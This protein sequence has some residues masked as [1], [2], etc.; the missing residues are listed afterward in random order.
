MNS[1]ACGR[2][3]CLHCLPTTLL[4]VTAPQ[5]EFP[6]PQVCWQSYLWVGCSQVGVRW[7]GGGGATTQIQRA[8]YLTRSYPI[9]VGWFHNS[10]TPCH[11][12]PCVRGD[13][14]RVFL[15]S[16]L[17]GLGE[18]LTSWSRNCLFTLHYNRSCGSLCRERGHSGAPQTLLTRTRARSAI[19]PVLRS[20]F[21]NQPKAVL[22]RGLGLGVISTWETS[23]VEKTQPEGLL[24]TLE[25]KPELPWQTD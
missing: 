13:L 9:A 25:R 12:L 16:Y 23:T 1:N 17:C 5:T 14:E 10:V 4:P 2:C 3:Y 19:R 18:S 24:G 6:N 11:N 20:L 21:H 22:R 7:G 15:F 8:F